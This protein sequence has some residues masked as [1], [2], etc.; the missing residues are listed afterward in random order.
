MVSTCF[1]ATLCFDSGSVAASAEVLGAPDSRGSEGGQLRASS[2][3]EPCKG[4]IR[5]ARSVPD[6]A[7]IKFDPDDHT[8]ANRR[9]VSQFDDVAASLPRQMAA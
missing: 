7:L 1:F 3:L 6:V 5:S 4:E 8:L 2:D 9:V